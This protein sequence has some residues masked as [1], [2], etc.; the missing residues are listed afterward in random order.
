MATMPGTH[1]CWTSE[2]EDELV[3]IRQIVS[4]LL[5]LRPFNP[6]HSTFIYVDASYLGFGCVLM[7]E[8]SQGVSHFVMAASSGITPAMTRYSVY[9]LELSALCWAL[10]KNSYYL[11]GGCRPVVLTD[12]RA[13]VGIETKSLEPDR[14]STRL[15]SSHSQQ[16][17]MPSSA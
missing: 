13:L 3:N 4:N 8:D 1:F 12:H 17:R 9:E 10:E 15:N 2:M 7:Q 14:K 6:Q 5:P 11:S 16:S